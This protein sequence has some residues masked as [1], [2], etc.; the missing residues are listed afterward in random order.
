MYVNTG[1]IW[2]RVCK[3]QNAGDEKHFTGHDVSLSVQFHIFVTKLYHNKCKTLY[4]FSV[5][6]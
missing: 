6:C 5:D 4:T 2:D 1:N 3:P